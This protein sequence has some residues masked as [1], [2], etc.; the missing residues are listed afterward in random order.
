MAGE[1]IWE[2]LEKIPAE[3]NS[4]QVAAISG[5]PSTVIAQPRTIAF[6]DFM[7]EKGYEVVGDVT[8]DDRTEVCLLYTS[9]CV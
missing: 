9:R 5:R 4:K 7:K 6:L 1:Y 2:Q 3:E 8:G